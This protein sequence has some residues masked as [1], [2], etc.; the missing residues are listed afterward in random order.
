MIPREESW[1]DGDEG[2]LVRPYTVSNGRTGPGTGLDL[3]SMVQSTGGA[4]PPGLEPDHAQALA[5]CRAPAS[6][7]EL[8]DRLRLPAAVTKVL[9]SDLLDNGAVTQVTAETAETG[10]ADVTAGLPPSAAT[11]ANRVVL[12]RVLDGLQRRL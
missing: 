6:V 3:T 2:R 10:P 12:E 7:A 11:P 4:P 5:L 1:L 8:A 9:L